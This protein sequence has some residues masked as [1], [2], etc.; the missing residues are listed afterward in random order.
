[1]STNRKRVAAVW[2]VLMAVSWPG[3]AA[4]PADKADVDVPRGPRVVVQQFH[5][6][7]AKGDPQAASRLVYS[8]LTE[9][10]SLSEHLQRW[11]KQMKAGKADFEILDEKADG[12][13]AAVVINENMKYGRRTTDYDPVY[14]IKADGRWQILFSPDYRDCG[15]DGQTVDRFELLEGWFE[16]Y[17]DKALKRERQKR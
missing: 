5:D 15:F 4:A 3:L 14:L 9:G 13:C 17:K 16:L 8:R 2:C 10:R 6:L 1:M 12:P 7:L 11:A